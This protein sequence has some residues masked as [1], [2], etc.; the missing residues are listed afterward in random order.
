MAT[1]IILFH[2][3]QNSMTVNEN[4]DNKNAHIHKYYTAQNPVTTANDLNEPVGQ[5]K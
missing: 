2:K 1:V 4:N 5:H 3:A